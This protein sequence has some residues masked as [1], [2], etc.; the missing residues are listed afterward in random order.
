MG[1]NGVISFGF[2]E[3]AYRYTLEHMDQ[4]IVA[5]FWGDIDIST[6]QGTIR[7]E[8][9]QSPSAAIDQVDS[10]ISSKIGSPFAGTWMLVA[11]WDNVPEF[12]FVYSQQFLV[13]YF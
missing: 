6:N 12:D 5:P 4:F 7:Y 8:V 13:R 11:Y 9:H 2:R 10:Y 3:T 1:T